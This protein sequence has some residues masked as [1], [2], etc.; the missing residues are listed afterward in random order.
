MKKKFTVLA[1][2]LFAISL[3]ANTGFSQLSGVKTID[4]TIVTGGNNYQTFT[5]AINALNGLG[6]GA[7]GV[8]FDVTSGQ[9][10]NEVPPVYD[11]YRNGR[12]TR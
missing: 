12:L 3:I 1:L 2:F 7:G 8:T 11:C 6:V 10:F 4:N 9:T 5:D